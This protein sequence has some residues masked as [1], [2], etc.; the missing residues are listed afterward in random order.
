MKTLIVLVVVLFLSA[1][2]AHD[3]GMVIPKESGVYSATSL[4]YS[5]QESGE[6][7][8]YTA[9]NTCEN[10]QLGHIVLKMT[11]TYQGQIDE[12]FNKSVNSAIN[13][14]SAINGQYYGSLSSG[15]DYKTVVTFK[16]E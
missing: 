9:K 14:V 4:S 6:A 10:K 16:C 5:E 13:I 1:C 7:A 15:S 8:L 11:T 12:S 2:A 3:L